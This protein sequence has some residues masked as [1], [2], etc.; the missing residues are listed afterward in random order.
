MKEYAMIL[1][2]LL[3]LTL[4]VSP[5]DV[6]TVNPDKPLKG[7]W[8][9]KLEKTWT[10]DKA[11]KDSL[12]APAVVVS[13]DG[14]VCV[15]DWKNRSYYLFNGGGGFKKAF[16]KPGEGPGEIRWHALPSFAIHNTFIAADMDRLHFFNHE[17]EF[18]KSI[19]HMFPG[20]EPLLFI[21]EDQL[22]AAPLFNLPE[23]KGDIYLCNLKTTGKKS[24]REFSVSGQE[25]RRGPVPHLFGLSP[26]PV[27]G[28]DDADKKLYYGVNDSYVI[29]VIDLNGNVL[30]TFSLDR[31]RRELSMETL[32]KQLDAID[33]GG[34]NSETV[35]LLPRELTHF[36]KI[37]IINGL[38]YI[39]QDNFGMNWDNQQIDIF[40]PGGKYLYRAVIRP[41]KGSSIYFSPNNFLIKNGHMYAVLEDAE[42]EIIIVKYK[43]T[44][45][46]E[47]T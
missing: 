47:E 46:K 43:I 36:R 6:K 15:R 27:V 40:S 13:D 25:N 30:N 31:K 21:D 22:I 29:Y 8:D 44:L 11:G 16:G 37:Q 24:I 26:M 2:L 42:G 23:G 32:K 35:K 14:N 17:G 12:A 10:I 5:A 38:V 39:F 33:P 28:Y 7:D 4:F 9:F 41:D 3:L 19:P 18:I 20:R 1:T 45:P 34:P